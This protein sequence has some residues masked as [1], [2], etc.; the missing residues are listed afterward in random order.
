MSDLNRCASCKH[1]EQVWADGSRDYDKGAGKIPEADR[2]EWGVCGLIQ[3]PDYSETVTTL[4]FTQD[5]SD[6][7]ADLHTRSD[8]GCVLWAG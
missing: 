3:M 1:W 5:G 6:Y 4:A 8:F 7:E 2:P